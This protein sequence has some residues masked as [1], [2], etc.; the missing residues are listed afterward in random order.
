[1]ANQFPTVVPAGFAGNIF[2][3]NKA[4]MDRSGAVRLYKGSVSVPSGTASGSKIGLVP[5]RAG[6]YLVNSASCINSDA[7][8]TTNTITFSAGVTYQ[9]GSSQTEAPATYVASG[10]TTLRT[11]ALGT[12]VFN[13]VEAG[14]TYKVL[15]DGWITLTTAAAATNATGNVN[16]NLAIAYDQGALS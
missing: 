4:K 5:V 2:D 13:T 9:A 16:F 7:L 12:T 8:D 6:A 15:D 10:A 11:N 14:L 3:F 1:M